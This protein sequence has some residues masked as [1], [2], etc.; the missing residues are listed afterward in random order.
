MITAIVYR[1]DAKEIVSK[2]A[3]AFGP[4][5]FSDASEAQVRAYCAELAR[6]DNIEKPDIIVEVGA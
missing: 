3:I 4:M 2:G 5:N 1:S 6:G